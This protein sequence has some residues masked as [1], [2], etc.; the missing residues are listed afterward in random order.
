MKEWREGRKREKRCRNEPKAEKDPRH[1]HFPVLVAGPI[2]S[3]P[4]HSTV[5][6]RGSG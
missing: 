5:S 4:S 3:L 6:L 1:S 2:K